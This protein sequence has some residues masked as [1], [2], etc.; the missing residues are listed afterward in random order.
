MSEELQS[1]F[2]LKSF[3]FLLFYFCFFFLK[4][5]FERE[6]IAG[7]AKL[8]ALQKTFDEK[9]L[10][11]R[12]REAAEKDDLLAQEDNEI[13]ELTLKWTR[14]KA[15][16][17]EKW[18]NTVSAEE[19]AQTKEKETESSLNKT[20]SSLQSR[21][22]AKQRVLESC[23]RFWLLL[24]HCLDVCFFIEAAAELVKKACQDDM[25]NI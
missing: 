11:L 6:K 4:I 1:E 9:L 13:A 19:I 21:I 25:D 18:A 14:K 20:L 2:F 3:L 10:A 17:E 8:K 7:K 15:A 23:T 5:E 16:F 24:D 22:A 12:N